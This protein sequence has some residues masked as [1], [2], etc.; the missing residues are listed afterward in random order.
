MNEEGIIVVE[1][2]V[3]HEIYSIPP[4]AT[5]R[6]KHYDIA[7]TRARRYNPPR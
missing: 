4:H 6:V 3:I 2:G 7:E 5:V 1:G